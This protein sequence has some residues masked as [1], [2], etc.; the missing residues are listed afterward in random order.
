M[1]NL[2]F[3][4]LPTRPLAAG[5]S[6]EER[7]P[8]AAAACGDPRRRAHCTAVADGPEARSIVHLP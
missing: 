8:S 4:V 7:V 3:R 2:G 1:T 6:A 5:A